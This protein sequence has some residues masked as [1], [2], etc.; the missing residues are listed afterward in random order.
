MRKER[1]VKTE[2]HWKIER[3]PRVRAKGRKARKEKH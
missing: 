1:Q 3:K 2:K